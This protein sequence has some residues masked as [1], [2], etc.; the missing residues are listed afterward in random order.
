MD[1]AKPQKE[2]V[3]LTVVRIFVALFLKT[4]DELSVL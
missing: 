1:D 4:I 2:Q 3:K